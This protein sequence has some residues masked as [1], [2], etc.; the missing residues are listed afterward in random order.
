MQ[1]ALLYAE[2][3]DVPFAFSSN[4]DGFL[5]HDRT[6]LTQPTERE[7]TLEQF[8]SHAELWA[9]YQQWKGL[10]DERAVQLIQQPYHSDGSG[11]EP[12]YYQRVAINRAI[13]AIAKG[14]QRV[15]LV[16]ATGTG[17]TYT[18]FQ[19]IWRLWKAKAKKRILFLADRNILVDQTMQQDFAPFGEVMHKVTNREVKKNYEI[20]LALYQAVTGKEE[21]KQITIFRDVDLDRDAAFDYTLEYEIR[22]H[23]VRIQADLA[24]QRRPFV[25]V[26]GDRVSQD[27]LNKNDPPDKTPRDERRGPRLLPSHVFAYYS[28]RNE[29]IEALFQDHQRRFNRLQDITTDEVLPEALRSYLEQLGFSRE[30]RDPMYQLFV[31]KMYEVR[32]QPMEQLLTPE[33]L[34]QQEALAAEI[35]KKLVV[36]EQEDELA[37]LVQQLQKEEGK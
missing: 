28:G 11:R 26:D 37:Q 35:V 29:R 15:L 34:K 10:T 25:W 30:Q 3:L 14:Q 27:Y 33:Q 23:V 24:K 7:L 8:P 19:I 4:G 5:M 20:Y 12:R 17:K 31:Q 32:S 22:G 16:M 21:W 1:Q 9:L 36:K 6:G 18:A 13:E 2:M